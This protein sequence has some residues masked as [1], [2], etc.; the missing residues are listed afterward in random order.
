MCK[1]AIHPFLAA[2]PKCE[3][4]AHLEGTLSPDL[5][6][7]LA[8]KNNIGLPQDDPAFKSPESLLERYAHFTSVDDFVH[9][10]S[11]GMSVLLTASDFQQLALAYFKHA[12]EDGV[13]HAE[14]FF[15][16]EEHTSRGVKYE[17]IVTGFKTA[18]EMAELELGITTKLILCVLRHF[19]VQSAMQTF[20]TAVAAGHFE[21][22]TLA[23]LGLNS[24]ELNNLPV[25]W[26]AVFE[27]AEKAGIRRTA[28]AAEEGP[29]QYIAD[30]L[31]ILHVQRIDHG[32]RLVED[33]V[34]MRIVADQGIMLTICPI[35]NVYLKVVSTIKD[36]PI[37]K[38]LD[39]GVRFS[40]NS[41]VPAYFGGILENY[42]AVQEAFQL[43]LEEWKVITE[44]AI[45]GSW[46]D[47]GRKTELS[48]AL[49]QCFNKFAS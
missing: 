30:A 38:F 14:V 28:H 8:K 22:G 20:H 9:Y 19:P 46:C 3:H 13:L 1:S 17:T 33:P 21:D 27:E 43:N 44:N 29:T 37:R 6:F 47:N 40:I 23:G 25:K 24:T 32:R 42:C 48:S 34:L 39:A 5:E 26:K 4:H 10:Y 18:C 45:Q 35:S 12:A 16:P 49:A 11:I 36:V 15:N 41:D 2:L 31:D 7:E